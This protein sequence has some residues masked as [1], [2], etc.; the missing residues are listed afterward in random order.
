MFKECSTSSADDNGNPV[1]IDSN[2]NAI[3]EFTIMSNSCPATGIN[4]LKRISNSE[5]EFKDFAMK[6]FKFPNYK[7][8]DTLGLT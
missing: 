8:G 4:F 2:G 3:D 5:S 7:K 1:L 6:A